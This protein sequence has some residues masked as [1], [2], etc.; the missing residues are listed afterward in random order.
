MR[1]IDEA[2]AELERELKVRKRCYP[3]WIKDGRLNEVDAEDRYDRLDTALTLLRQE[4]QK[5][6]LTL[7]PQG[8]LDSEQHGTEQ[9]RAAQ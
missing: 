3:G 4:R 1:S 5:K 6:V 7:P 8:V 2:I 9:D